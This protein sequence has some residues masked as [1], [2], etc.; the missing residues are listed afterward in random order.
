[1]VAP[2]R[3]LLAALAALPLAA[4]GFRV[5]GSQELAFA[6][7]AIRAPANSPVGTELARNLRAGGH[8]RVVAEPAGAEAVLDLLGE[9]RDRQLLSLNAQG[10]AVE[11][12]LH[13]RLRFR[14]R[15]ARGNELIEPTELHAV[16]D[17]SINDSQVISKES[18]QALLYREMESDLVQQ[19]LRRL[20]AARPAKPDADRP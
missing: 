2:R 11:Y 12:Q 8:T 19:M 7:I 16:R 15:D 10:R 9:T 3:R 4:C 6:T 18:E 1:M 5:R 20:V 13:L 17:I 14:L